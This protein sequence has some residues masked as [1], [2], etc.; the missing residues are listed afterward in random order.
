[1]INYNNRKFRGR[2]NS[3]NGE[4]D[5][6]TIF[7]Y[8]QEDDRLRG[9]YSGGAIETGQLVGTVQE[10]GSLNFLYHHLT[11]NGTLMAGECHS[12]PVPGEDGRLIL[13]ERWRWLTGDLSSGV[14]EVEE[15]LDGE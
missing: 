15:I 11:A 14:S 6:E 1:M 9:T 3:P 13:Q 12:E 4:V 7:H 10:D 8:H 2:T 5:R